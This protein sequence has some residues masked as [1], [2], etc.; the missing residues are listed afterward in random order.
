MGPLSL[1]LVKYLF[2]GSIGFA[3][4][5]GLLSIL[6]RLFN[7][8]PFLAR[9]PSFIAAVIVT[10][11][12]HRNHTFAGRS[13]HTPGEEF[14]RYFLSQLAGGLTNV[15]IYA[16]C[17]A[18]IPLCARFPEAAVAIA[19]GVALVVNFINARVF[20]FP[21]GGEISRDLPSET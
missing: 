4:D 10:W 2:V 12:L 9:V 19:S 15:T 6:V 14:R 11:W 13:R 7:A 16:I 5:A 20:V 18:F 3:I 8:D 1:V 21:G 17:I